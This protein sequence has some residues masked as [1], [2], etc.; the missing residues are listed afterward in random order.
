MKTIKKRVLVVVFMLGTLFNYAN[1]VKDF[2]ETVNAKK[3]KVVFEDVKKGQQL[4][5]KDNNG[6]KLHSESVDKA[7]NLIKFFDLSFLENGIYTIE[8]NKHFIIAVKVIEVKD[9]NVAFMDD[10]EKVIFK[11][12]IKNK[13]NLVLISKVDF[14]KKPLKVAIFFNDE[15]IFSET[16]KGEVVLK[17]AYRLDENIKGNYK[18][19]VYCDDTDYTNEFT[20]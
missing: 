11:P 1:T 12:I 14:D 5:I 13:E 6:I 8:L 2:N 19:I 4:T 10:S 15:V 17:R 20:L 9:K 3:V 7:G 16:I 18:V